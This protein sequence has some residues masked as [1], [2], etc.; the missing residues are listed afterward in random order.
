[1][2]ELDPIS[3][4]KALADPTRLRLL[5]L[6]GEEELSV[7]ELTTILGMT[8]SRV[9]GHLAVLRDAELVRDRRQGTSAF[10]SL[11][12]EGASLTTWEA[13]R[14]TLPPSPKADGDR[15]RLARVLDKRRERDREFFDRVAGGLEARS[16]ALGLNAGTACLAA[17]IPEDSTVLDLG[18]GTGALLPLLAGSVRRV[19]AVDASRTML[20]RARSRARESELKGTQFLR[21]DLERLPV[22]DASV[23]GVVA[24]MVLHHLAQPERLFR[25]MAR[26]L[27]PGGRAAV[28]D[29]ETHEE[30]W[31]LEEEGHRWAGFDPAQ[32]GA[33][34]VDSGLGVP[35]FARVPTPDTGRWSRLEVFA[36]SLGR[37]RV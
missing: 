11:D 2:K 23:D 12:P 17:L 28:V 24:N 35:R 21:G 36:A 13:V 30:S 6:L 18:T 25:E 1:M 29:F 14:A 8:Q 7:G 31:L 15:R 10:Y 20:D 32:I 34:S 37:K 27:R 22:A 26:V 19:I 33:W 9:S 5:A 16:E 4:L 3:R